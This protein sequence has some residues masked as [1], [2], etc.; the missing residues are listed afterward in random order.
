M[1]KEKKKSGLGKFVA[2]VAIGTGIGVLFAPKKGSETRA[3]LKAKLEELY[4]KA[5]E[6]DMEEVKENIEIKIA[7]IKAGLEDLDKE[8]VIE[9]A[10]TKA[11]QLQ[12]MCEELV[13]Y[14]VEKGTPVMEKTAATVREKTATVCRE[15]LEKLKADEKQKLEE[16]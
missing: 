9:I 8:K 13:Q 10:K 3:E 2:G 15:V 12:N 16:K 7:E 5:K 11:K 4:K 1:S 6:L 14:V